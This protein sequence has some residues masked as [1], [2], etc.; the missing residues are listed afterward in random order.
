M[1]R[2]LDFIEQ[3]EIYPQLLVYWGSRGGGLRLLVELV[4]EIT[5][6]G[7]TKILLSVNEQT[8]T[9]LSSEF[10]DI[11][12]VNAKSPELNSAIGV[13]KFYLHRKSRVCRRDIYSLAAEYRIKTVVILMA[14]PGDLTLNQM[15]NHDLRVVRV[16]H[17]FQRHPGDIWPTKP[18]IKL[19]LRVDSIIV[20][21]KFV[22]DRV[23]HK[24]KTLSSLSRRRYRL[25]MENNL[26]LP[27]SYIL[28]AG[29]FKKYKNLK[30]VRRAIINSPQLS[31]VCAGEGSSKFKDLNN[32]VTIPT[33]LSE[34]TLEFLIKNSQG[35]VAIY[36][37][38]SQSGIVD[39]AVYWRVPVLVSNVGALPEQ[40]ACQ[41]TNLVCDHENVLSITEGFSTL[42]RIEK[43]QIP[44]QQIHQTL[45]ETLI[46][47]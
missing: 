23:N 25:E 9:N 13:F 38:A 34:Q 2:P 12:F 18:E 19:M 46:K 21:S 45:F 20:L 39:Q 33:W 27:D 22:F 11:E 26:E 14:H 35:L 4:F 29:R 36:S 8:Y 31:F 7:Y 44:P 37:E 47:I 41:K 28:I 16:I 3:Q 24:S 15:S 30:M 40:I 32:V 1:D 5:T 6:H 43:S 17:D 10:P 42:A